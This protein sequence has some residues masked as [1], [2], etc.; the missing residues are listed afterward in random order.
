MFK[1]LTAGFILS[2]L[3]LGLN[4][5]VVG[6]KHNKLFN[7]YVLEK[8]EDVYY[9]A[10]KMSEKDKYRD[11]AEVYLY[12]T[13]ALHQLAMNPDMEEAYPDAYKD[14]LKYGSKFVKYS[15]KAIEKERE[16]VTAEDNYE[17]LQELKEYIMEK[18]FFIFVERKYSKAAS[19]YR[20]AMKIFP[21][22]ENILYIAGISEMMS[23]NRQ[24]QMKL[25]E[26]KKIVEDE[27]KSG[28]YEGDEVSNP[29]YVKCMKTWTNYLVT[30]GETAQAK[31]WVE[32]AFKLFPQNDGVK[33][34]YNKLMN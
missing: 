21:E 32:L 18:T 19:R 11:D 6:G 33:D 26:Y 12:M 14:I 15:T 30:E 16:T 13:M 31:E 7:M 10:F 5:Q 8:Y 3:A 2:V 4:A 27:M 17:Y 1:Q 23:R 24:G 28:D 20:K 9:K 29:Y 25:D 34:Q 22:D